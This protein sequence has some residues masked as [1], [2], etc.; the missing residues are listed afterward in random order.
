MLIQMEGLASAGVGGT[1]SLY[2]DLKEGSSSQKAGDSEPDE[3]RQRLR[4]CHED[5]SG[6]LRRSV[7][8]L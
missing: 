3:T 7:S 6:Y 1:D 2:D 8:I 4:P 5:F